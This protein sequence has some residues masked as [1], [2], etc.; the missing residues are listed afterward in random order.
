MLLPLMEPLWPD[1]V[2]WLFMPAPLVVPA[3]PPMVAPVEDPLPCGMVLVVP[4]LPEVAPPELMVLWLDVP[5][6]ACA[7]RQNRAAPVIRAATETNRFID[8]L[9]RSRARK[10]K[11]PY[12]A[13]TGRV[14]NE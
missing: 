12:A 1:M 6:C 2:P 13:A 9:I 7:G 14:I 10:P 3:V 11:H 5:V 4:A 8:H